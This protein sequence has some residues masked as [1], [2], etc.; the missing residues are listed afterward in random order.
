MTRAAAGGAAKAL[1]LAR[2]EFAPPARV[3]AA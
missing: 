2:V 3:E 1:D